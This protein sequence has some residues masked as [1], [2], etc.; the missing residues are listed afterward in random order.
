MRRV[1]ITG[2][3]GF[4]GGA[5]VRHLAGQGWQVTAA[6][7]DASKLAALKTT[8]C[9]VLA[10]D[11]AQA[12]IYNVSADAVVHCAA[13]SSPFGRLADFHAAN[14]L[15]TQ[16]ALN[17]ARRSGAERFVQISSPTVYFA[18]RDQEG[19]RETLPLPKPIN[20][21]ALTKAAADHAVMA[22]S[23]LHTTILRPRGIYGAGDTAL[24]PRM[25]A[26][27]RRGPLPLLRKGAA[28][29][30]LTHVS[31]VCRAIEA[32]LGATTA[33]GDVF[34]ISGG[35]PLSVRHIV[36]SACAR[37]GVNARWRALPLPPLRLIARTL[38]G[39]NARLP[40]Q[41]E[42]RITPYTLGLFAY[43]QS[44]DISKAQAQLNWS[45]EVSFETGL[46]RTFSEAP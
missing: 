26:A 43:R 42:P 18:M 36:D 7:R 5:L 35:E 30:D 22:T 34:N 28:S 25:M 19:V 46:A 45:P 40:H 10:Q 37:L 13:L 31:D 9:A 20:H 39:V 3:T 14:V 11:L 38:E 41:P 23:D 1:L 17:T 32:A 21:Y 44:L 27:A 2:A 15:A 6:G 29:I 24:L 8:G 12:P 16:N 4:L 33:S